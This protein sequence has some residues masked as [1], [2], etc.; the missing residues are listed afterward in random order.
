MDSRMKGVL[1]HNEGN[2]GNDRLVR[3]MND[4]GLEK[5]REG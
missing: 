4:N 2:T 3:S 5:D 1:L